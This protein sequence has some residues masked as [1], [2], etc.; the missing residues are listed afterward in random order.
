[1]TT[2]SAAKDLVQ[3]I[4][5]LLDGGSAARQVRLL[6]VNRLLLLPPACENRF[7]QDR[8]VGRC[9]LQPL[10][11]VDDQPFLGPATFPGQAAAFAALLSL[12]PSAFLPI[13]GG[14]GVRKSVTSPPA[15]AGRLSKR[16]VV[17]IACPNT[18]IVDLAGPAEVFCSHGHCAGQRSDGR[19]GLSRGTRVDDERT[20]HD[21]LR[22]FA[23]E[24][25]SL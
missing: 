11:L 1:M 18:H 6:A 20:A 7:P 2:P 9:R 15:R 21:E 10:Q 4:D 8:H 19:F 5:A 17:L 22:H 25:W 3:A 23:R 14:M 13:V 16:R 12:L 24:P